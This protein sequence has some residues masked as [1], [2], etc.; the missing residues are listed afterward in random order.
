MN[1]ER[2][3]LGE[4]LKLDHM[5]GTSYDGYFLLT[6]DICSSTIIDQDMFQTCLPNRTKYIIGFGQGGPG[7]EPVVDFDRPFL[8]LRLIING[9]NELESQSWRNNEFF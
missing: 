9:C 7:T 5:G 1:S 3:E 6:R 2:W 8:L 4:A